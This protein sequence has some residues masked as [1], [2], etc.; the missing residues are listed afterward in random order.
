MSLKFRFMDTGDGYKCLVL[1]E[2]TEHFS[3]FLNL[4]VCIQLYINTPIVM[5]HA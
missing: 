3:P 2:L 1:F 4:L 5:P